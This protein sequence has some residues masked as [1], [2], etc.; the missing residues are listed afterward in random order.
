MTGL[1]TSRETNPRVLI[2]KAREALRAGRLWE[3]DEISRGLLARDPDNAAAQAAMGMVAGQTA[4][5]DFGIQLLEK[6]CP[7]LPEDTEALNSLALLYRQ[8]G[9]LPDA[10]AIWA[11][12]LERQPTNPEVNNSLG[13]C[14]L[15]QDRVE[16]AL[17]LFDRAVQYG[18]S[19]A[20][21]HHNRGL[22]LERLGRRP[23]AAE[24]YRRA[25]SAAPKVA[26]SYISLAHLLL[27]NN[28]YTLAIERFR[29]AYE[30]EPNTCRGNL[31]MAQALMEEEKLEEA[32]PFLRK[33]VSLDPR[34]GEAHGMLGTALQ[35]LGDFE[36]SGRLLLRAMEL[37]PD[38][39]AAYSG[40]STG[41]KFTEEDRP[42]VEKMLSILESRPLT[43]DGKEQIHYAVA[44]ALDDL[45]DHENAMRHFD[46]ANKNAEYRLVSAGRSINREGF[47]NYFNVMME[48]FTPEHFASKRYMGSD[49][50]LPIFVVG[51]I[52]S[53]TTLTEQIIS[54]HPKV[55]AAGEARYWVE[56]ARE[57]GKFLPWVVTEA[58]ARRSATEYLE[59]LQNMAPGMSRVTDKMPLNF[60][61]LGPIHTVFPNAKIIHCQRNPIDNCLSIYMT[62]YR[63]SPEY[64]H[65]RENMVFFYRLYEKLMAH[66]RAVLPPDRFFEVRYEELVADPEGTTRQMIEFLGLE[67][68]DACLHHDQNERS[69][70]TPS[71]WQA[72]QPIYKSS[73]EK[74]RKYEPW[75]GA[76]RE[77][78]PE[79]ERGK[80]S[81]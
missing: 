45:K 57:P 7:R 6:A 30:L 9:R 4:R 33:A 60:M 21:H 61:S 34:S 22:A 75:L 51:M 56:H 81:A 35:Q 25:I 73:A 46:E 71:L 62:R 80:T 44:K 38:L 3:A 20:T 49:S 64:G 52:R 47:I 58:D 43:R 18:P 26:H 65:N 17:A 70:R 53:G 15:D 41:K 68:D 28:E 42:L 72:R 2:Q 14:R 8:V 54:S 32:I 79:S 74:W 24:A 29:Q 1:P 63:S 5:L 23:E 10:E 16:E 40:F 59:V 69:V 50:D 36:E 13:M 78:L 31:Q 37:Q 66:W 27:S 39:G 67:W 77:L 12:L 19:A 11:K 55:G 48:T 76:F